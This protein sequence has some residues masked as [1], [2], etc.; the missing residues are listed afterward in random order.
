APS[1]EIFAAAVAY[2]EWAKGPEQQ[3][4]RQV[5]D[6]LLECYNEDWADATGRSPLKR[7]EFLAILRPSSIRLHLDG[8]AIWYYEARDLFAGHSIEV[9]ASAEREFSDPHLI[10]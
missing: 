5:A 1:E 4:R 2:L 7:E 9:W 3:C 6:D 8:D 10:G